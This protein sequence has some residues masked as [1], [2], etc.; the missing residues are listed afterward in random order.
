[1]QPGSSD[2]CHKRALTVAAA[3]SGVE[4][5]AVAGRDKDLLVVTG[6][7]VDAT[8]LT[9]KLKEE[10]GEAEI[11]ELRTLGGNNGAP[12]SKDYNIAAAQYYSRSPYPGVLPS[13]SP[14]SYDYGY[15]SAVAAG[16]DYGSSSYARA[17]ACSH[18]A[19]YSPM[20]ERHDYGAAG[21]WSGAGKCRRGEPSCCP[22]L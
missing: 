18:P 7:G 20:I 12:S 15:A 16:Y 21:R 2:K 5:I 13:S 17:V 11:V 1:M 10:V 19:N 22:I 9:K 3:A 4:S 6:D 8:K 14:S